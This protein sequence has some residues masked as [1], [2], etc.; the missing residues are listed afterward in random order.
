MAETDMVQNSV[1]FASSASS[2]IELPGGRQ[3][4][5]EPKAPFEAKRE[6]STMAAR[7]NCHTGRALSKEWNWARRARLEGQR[8]VVRPDENAVPDAQ[9]FQH[10]PAWKEA[11]QES[12]RDGFGLGMK[13]WTHNVIGVEQDWQEWAATAELTC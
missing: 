12:A 3:S 5:R 2:W 10:T 7:R 11:V 8:N 1:P 13:R 9:G 6:S 4:W